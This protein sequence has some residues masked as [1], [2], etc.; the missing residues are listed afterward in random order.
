MTVIAETTARLQSEVADLRQIGGAAEFEA[1]SANSPRATP[2]A[3]VIPL[4]EDPRPSSGA[5][6]IRQQ[7]RVS[8]GVVLAV[9]NV[10]DTKG[11][12]AQVDLGVL[13]PA[14]QTALLG[15][16]PTGAEPLERGAGR[17]IGMKNGV[18]Y[19]QDVYHTNIYARD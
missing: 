10:A 16:S 11:E 3:F 5:N 6:F 7:I 17:L 14:V 15:W 12:A 1:A 8:V 13:R 9:K 19:W 2:A 4:G 18:L